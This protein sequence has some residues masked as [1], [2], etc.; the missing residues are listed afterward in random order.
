MDA[1]AGAVQAIKLRYPRGGIRLYSVDDMKS[2]IQ[3]W[4]ADASDVVEVAKTY[5]EVLL[6]TEKQ[7]EY[8]MGQLV[9]KCEN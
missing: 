1:A 7:M 8:M 2:C 3:E 5:N 6:E 4:F 9:G